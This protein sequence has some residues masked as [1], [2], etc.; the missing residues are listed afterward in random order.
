MERYRREG[1][2]TNSWG[3]VQDERGRILGR[4]KTISPLLESDVQIVKQFLIEIQKGKL[5]DMGKQNGQRESSTD[6]VNMAFL[7]G[8]ITSLNVRDDGS[9]YLKIDPS[10]DENSK[11]IP[12]TIYNDEE[13]AGML[14]RFEVGDYIQVRGYVRAWSQKKNN[15]WQNHVEIRVTEIRNSPPVREKKKPA[16]TRDTVPTSMNDDDIPF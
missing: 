12:C 15:E 3:I 14:G 16:P 8:E 10:G 11:W 9:A 5:D 4:M 13:L 1:K 2:P 7:A 6:R